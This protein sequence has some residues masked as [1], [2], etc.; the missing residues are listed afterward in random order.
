M[1]PYC[2]CVPHRLGLSYY[3]THSFSHDFHEKIIPNVLLSLREN[4]GACI[5]VNSPKMWHD[6]LRTSAELDPLCVETRALRILF[7]RLGLSLSFTKYWKTWISL[8]LSIVL[9]DWYQSKWIFKGFLWGVGEPQPLLPVLFLQGRWISV[10]VKVIYERCSSIFPINV[11][12][13]LVLGTSHVYLL[14]LWA[15]L[16]SLSHPVGA[17]KFQNTASTLVLFWKVI[18]L[19]GNLVVLL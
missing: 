3:S 10:K 13:R 7:H 9:C 5:P 16:Q 19:Y 6:F 18:F 14:L 8:W 15:F 2:L 17:G 11:V 4:Y 12:F 1:C